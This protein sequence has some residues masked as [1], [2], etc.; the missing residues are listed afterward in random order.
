MEGLAQPGQIQEN[1][2]EEVPEN[3]P[4]FQGEGDPNIGAG[5][6]EE[7]ASPQEQKMYDAIVEPMLGMVHGEK[8]ADKIIESLKGGMSIGNLTFQIGMVI[9]GEIEKQGKSVPDEILQMAAEDV[10]EDLVEIS[11][12]IGLIPDEQEKIEQAYIQGLMEAIDLYG[13]KQRQAGKVTQEGGAKHI[14]EMTALGGFEKNKTADA[15]QQ[16]TNQGV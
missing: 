10:V 3:D 16:A 1:M 9:V 5:L 8:T 7:Q 13:Q 11:V 12:S 15:V 14:N 4:R 2:P 6:K